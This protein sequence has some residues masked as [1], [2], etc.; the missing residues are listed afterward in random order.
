VSTDAGAEERRR[1]RAYNAAA[2]AAWRD[3]P[4]AAMRR[5]GLPCWHGDY[6]G[7]PSCDEARSGGGVAEDAL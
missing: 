4:E 5:F 2:E 7:C 3:D 6:G 1:R